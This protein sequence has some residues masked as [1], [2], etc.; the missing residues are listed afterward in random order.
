MK[1]KIYWFRCDFQIKENEYGDTVYSAFELAKN[2][3]EAIRIRIRNS[4][5]CGQTIYNVVAKQIKHP[6]NE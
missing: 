5:A 4:K 1:N 6:Y 2:Q 3:E